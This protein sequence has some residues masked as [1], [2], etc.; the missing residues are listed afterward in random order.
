MSDLLGNI[1]INDFSTWIISLLKIFWEVF[2][3]ALIISH[4]K[5]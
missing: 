5:Y 4:N 1:I 2:V 3:F